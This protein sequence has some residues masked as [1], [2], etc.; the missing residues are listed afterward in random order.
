MIITTDALRC[1][2][3]FNVVAGQEEAIFNMLYTYSKTSCF[4]N[5]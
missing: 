5:L 4:I 2:Q 1:Q 3:N